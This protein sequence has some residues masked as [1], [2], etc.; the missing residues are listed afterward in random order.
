MAALLSKRRKSKKKELVQRDEEIQRI[1]EKDDMEEAQKIR[2]L[3]I[4]RFSSINLTDSSFDWLSY[5][6]TNVI[7]MSCQA[8][9][10]REN[11]CSFK[12]YPQI[13]TI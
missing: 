13:P 11:Q 6:T 2:L 9:M 1:A 8:R 12:L 3:L 4:G 5:G 10:I 7:L